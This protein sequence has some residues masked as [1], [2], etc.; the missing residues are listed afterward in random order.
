MLS[1]SSASQIRDSNEAQRIG[2]VQK[3]TKM[4]M[5]SFTFQP[6]SG[7]EG[8]YRI[9]TCME[10]K[11]NPQNYLPRLVYLVLWILCGKLEIKCYQLKQKHESLKQGASRPRI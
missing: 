1:I 2:K 7:S 5:A 8:K 11:S 10:K 6:V 3:P 4:Q 9:V